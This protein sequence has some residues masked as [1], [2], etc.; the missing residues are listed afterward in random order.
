M[1]YMCKM[2]HCDAAAHKEQS[3]LQAMEPSQAAGHTARQGDALAQAGDRAAALSA[4]QA[5]ILELA[6]QDAPLEATLEAIVLTVENLS[7]T[8]VLG[9]ILLLDEDGIHLRHGAGPSLP[10]AYNDVV[11]GIAIGPAVGSCGTAIFRG[12][13]VFVSD[14]AHDPLWADFR[15]LTLGYG[16]RACWSLPIR[17]AKGKVI[18]T[19]AMYHREPREPVETDLEIVDF[20]VRTAGIV[21]GR[22]R[23]EAAIRQSEKRYRQ[24]VEGAEDFAI[25]SLDPVGVITGW[26]SGAQR[27]IGWS[28][29]EAIGQHCSLF[30]TPEDQAAHVP[31]HEM[32]QA[33]VL[34]RGVDERWHIRKD[35]R[36]FWASGLTMPVAGS[37]GGYVKIFRDQTSQHEAEA[38][39]RESEARLR[40]WRDG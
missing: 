35:G 39:L 18:G 16:L 11:D 5:R 23:S 19:F 37:G 27:L 15:D 1:L 32:K 34:G 14:I 12:E 7:T 17:S 40:F 3:L 6:V 8:G 21:I 24:I 33:D 30:F 20:V 2:R 26:N 36:R 31:E 9:S 13:P 29:Q 10:P 4:A 38:A 28:P 22:A 25:V